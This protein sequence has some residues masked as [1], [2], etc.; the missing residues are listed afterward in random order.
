MAQCTKQHDFIITPRLI[1][2]PIK[3]FSKKL[4]RV[5]KKNEKIQISRRAFCLLYDLSQKHAFCYFSFFQPMEELS[6]DTA[7]LIIERF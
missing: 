7:E 5:S 4:I 1:S 3:E 6:L 2:F